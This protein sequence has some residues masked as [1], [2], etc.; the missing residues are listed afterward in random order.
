MAAQKV[1]PAGYQLKIALQEIEPPIWR[2]IQLPNT[3]LLCRLHNAFDNWRHEVVLEKIVPPGDPPNKP[4][5]LGGERRCP[6]EDV[7]GVT[8]YGEFL[9]A[10]CD[11]NHDEYEAMVRW[12]GGHFHDTFDV[13]ATNEILGRM[14]WPLRHR[15]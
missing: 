6:P 1:T 3:M 10:I 7:G 15:R 13:K 2:R 5:C 12:A 14:R 11:P 4:I 8:G 9:E